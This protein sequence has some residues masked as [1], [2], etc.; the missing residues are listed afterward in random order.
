MFNEEMDTDPREIEIVPP[1]GNV[2]ASD[3]ILQPVRNLMRTRVTTS[4][5]EESVAGAVRLMTEEHCGCVLVTEHGRLVGILSERDVMTRLVDRALDAAR[6]IVRDHMTAAPETLRPDDA[7]A[8]ALN[9][10]TVGGFRHVPIVDASGRLEG[11]VSIRDVQRFLSAHFRE[12]IL[13]LPPRPP[14][15]GPADRYGG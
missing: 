8:Y 14:R 9:I 10:M 4:R 7:L 6:E 15:G 13:T 5:P 2:L 11:I 3:S 1:R 12:E